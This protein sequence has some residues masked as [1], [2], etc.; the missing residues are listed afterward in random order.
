[1]VNGFDAFGKFRGKD[2]GFPHDL[3]AGGQDRNLG[4]GVILFVADDAISPDE[5]L[6]TIAAFGG[7]AQDSDALATTTDIKQLRVSL[8]E[9]S[10]ISIEGFWTIT[11]V[12]GTLGDKTL[13]VCLSM[14]AESPDPASPL[15]P[16]GC[17]PHSR[18]IARFSEPCVPSTVGKSALLDGKPFLGNLPLIATP[19]SP[20]A[21]PLPHTYV[22]A[23]LNSA[24]SPLYIP[25]DVEPLN[26]NNL[27]TY[28]ITP[29]VDLPTNRR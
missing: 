16:H 14:A 12:D 29:L 18:F 21:P 4:V 24:T 8:S 9:L 3:T 2:A 6:D 15:D 25:G 28:V 23:T 26:T 22:T 11:I 17:S 27:A 10:G 1:M 5:K 20:P 13:P 19:P 7:S